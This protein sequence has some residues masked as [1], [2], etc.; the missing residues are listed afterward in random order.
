L[1]NTILI[2][3][4]STQGAGALAMLLSANRI[5][6]FDNNWATSTK[7]V[8]DFFKPYRTISKQ[9]MKKRQ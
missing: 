5:I 7:G 4:V 8:F 9:E 6:A 2:L 3:V 1:Q